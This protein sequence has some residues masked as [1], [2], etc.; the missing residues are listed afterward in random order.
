MGL[1]IRLWRAGRC[2]LYALERNGVCL[3]NAF[4]ERLALHAESDAVRLSSF[5]TMLLDECIIRPMYLRDE[6]PDLGV[7]AMYNHRPMPKASY[8]Q[9]RLLCAFIEST[10]TIMI[11]GDGFYKVDDEPIQANAMANSMAVELARA[12]KEV[13]RRIHTGEISVD[14]SLLVPQYHDSFEL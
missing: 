12:V 11:V 13:N 1:R 3:P 2:S 14:G 8:N 5:I 7:Y 9:S 10:N 4:L 6:R